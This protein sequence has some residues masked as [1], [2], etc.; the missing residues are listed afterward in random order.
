MS[1]KRTAAGRRIGIVLALALA[2]SSSGP[3]AWAQ[4][5]Q[6]ADAVKEAESRFKE[7]LKRH[8][9]GDEEGARLSFLQAFSVLKRANI[10]FNL[11]RAEQLTN[12]PVD[13]IGHYKLY[14][15][16][17]TV[18]A[19]DREAARKRIVELSALVGH[20]VID[21]PSGADLWIDGQMLPR[22]APLGEPADAAGG[23]HTVQ[24]R[25][26]D[27]TKTATVACS[28]GQTVTVKIEIEVIPGTPLVVVPMPGEG[29]PS[30]APLPTQEK[31]FHYETQGA[32][33]VT[34]IALGAGAVGLLAGGIG[35]EAA[36]SSASSTGTTDRAALQ[37]GGTSTS[38]C[39]GS[40]SMACSNLASENAS[41][42]S[43]RN[44]AVGLFVGVGVV[45][46][47][48]GVTFAVW[49]KTKV[50]D[51]QVSA[52]VSP[53]MKGLTFGGTF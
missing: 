47:A 43:D 1:I 4:P 19:V 42:S 50:F 28:P 37:K 32:K 36:G 49:P 31:P 6:T 40:T 10:L 34:M 14:V 17:S 41:A 39:T 46:A 52:L 44:A 22:K 51:G 16:D 11:A 15:A 18:T 20:I 27:Q 23:M 7:G 3:A 45:A 33:V 21:A 29:E 8:D 24:A 12:H 30:P 38:V 25:S 26:G 5:A 13:A 35:L 53:T 9:A 2:T 48:L